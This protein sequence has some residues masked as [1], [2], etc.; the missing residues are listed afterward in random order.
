[1]RTSAFAFVLLAA[2]VVGISFAIPA[3]DDPETPYDESQLLPYEAISPLVNIVMRQT[4][5]SQTV[6]KTDLVARLRCIAASNETRVKQSEPP[7][8]YSSKSITV[9]NCLRRC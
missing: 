3:E 5:A 2:L 9:L 6:P 8:Q 1:M 4:A 7:R